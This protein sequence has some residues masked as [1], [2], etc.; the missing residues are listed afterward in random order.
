LRCEIVNDALDA[1]SAVAVSGAPSLQFELEMDDNND[2]I[3]DDADNIQ[4]LMHD[5]NDGPSDTN[6]VCPTDADAITDSQ[7]M[8]SMDHKWTI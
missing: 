6:C 2:A 5:A 7:F 1:L 8:F 3:F 4:M